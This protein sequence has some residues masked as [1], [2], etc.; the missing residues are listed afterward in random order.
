MVFRVPPVR[1]A[2]GSG[3]SCDGP[4]PPRPLPDAD[5]DGDGLISLEEAA[6]YYGPIDVSLTTT[7]D[8]S[9]ASGLALER[10]PVA[11]ANGVIDYHRTVT[12]PKDVSKRLGE[13]HLVLHGADVDGDGTSQTTLM[14]AVLPVAC[15]EIDRAQGGGH[16]H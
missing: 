8:T 11:D 4:D 1:R 9:P 14:E 15:G 16:R 6:P 3:R 2:R 7:G 13:L 5:A 10:F 12:V